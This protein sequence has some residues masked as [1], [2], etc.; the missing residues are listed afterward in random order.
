MDARF[1]IGLLLSLASLVVPRAAQAHA[2]LAHA[3][4]RVGSA[5]RSPPAT[6]TLTFTEDIEAAFSKIEVSDGDG[7]AVPV[8]TLEHPAEGVLRVSLP[9]LRAGTYRVN[10]KV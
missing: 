1:A 2:F 6:V 5:V 9:T 4:P 3:D 7:K 10:W 8:G